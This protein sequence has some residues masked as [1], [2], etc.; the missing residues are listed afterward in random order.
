MINRMNCTGVWI[1]DGEKAYDFYANKLGFKVTQDKKFG[2][3]GRFFM[4]LPPGGGAQLNVC[5]P[6]PGMAGAQVGVQTPIVWETDDINATYE[7]LRAKGVEFPQ[8]PTQ[9]FWGGFE[10]TFKDP[11]GNLFKLL[12]LSA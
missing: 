6:A 12:Q 5:T 8:P 9:Q 3:G 11:D 10:A 4:V 2:E 7:D 1:N